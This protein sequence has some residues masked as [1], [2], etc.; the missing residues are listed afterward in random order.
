MKFIKIYLL[1]LYIF[2]GTF[3]WGIRHT[4]SLLLFAGVAITYMLRVSL[5]VAI[6]AMTDN[7]RSNNNFKVSYLHIVPHLIYEIFKNYFRNLY[8]FKVI[9]NNLQW[10]K[11]IFKKIEN[12]VMFIIILFQVMMS[13][14]KWFWWHFWNANH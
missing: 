14:I 9:S 2:L 10:T 13:Q 5:S 8:S 4:Q 1:F 12:F 3:R 6:V 7:S 11:N